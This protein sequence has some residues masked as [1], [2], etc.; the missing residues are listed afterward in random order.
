MKRKFWASTLALIMVLALCIGAFAA[1]DNGEQDP[2]TEPTYYTVTFDLDGG[3]IA[4]QDV[5]KGLQIEKGA[6]LNLSNY[7][8]T[9]EG[10]SFNG[11]KAGDMA[12]AQDDTLTINSNVTL[13]AQWTANT[14]TVTFILA[15]GE[16][17]ETTLSL[18]YGAT[19][20]FSDY[21]PTRG[22]YAFQGWKAGDGTEYT[23][24]DSLTVQA[25]ITLTAQWDLDVSPLDQ[26]EFSE[27][28]NGEVSLIG[29]ADSFDLE[30]VVLPAEDADGN[31]ITA[32]G[33]RAFQNQY[34]N[35]TSSI[36][37]IYLD[38]MTYLKAIGQHAFSNIASLEVLSLC[39]LSNLTEIQSSAFY[40][41]VSSGGAPGSL[42]SVDFTG[43]ESL[44]I[45]QQSAFWHQEKLKEVDL[46]GCTSL[47]NIERQAFA[48]C[49]SLETVK[50]PYNLQYIGG[51]NEEISSKDSQFFWDCN[52][53]KEI[54]VDPLNLYF[55]SENGVFYT[56]GK[57]DL[58]K[59]PVASDLSEY[60]A[61]ASV[62]SVWGQAFNGAENLKKIDFS[63]CFL[64]NIDSN[65]FTGCINAEL[66]VPFDDRGYYQ[67]GT[68]C[69][70]GNNWNG[71]VK[72][73]VFGEKYYF[74]EPTFKGIED[75]M[76]TAQETLSFDAEV[77]Y[78]KY[79]CSLTVM[80]ETT[81]TAGT[82]E[83][84]SYSV[85]LQ[86]GENEITVIARCAEKDAEKTF[87]FTVTLDDSLTVVS[88]LKSEGLNNVSDGY[89]FTV[90]VQN[91]EGESIS[92]QN[93]LKVAVDCGYSA[94][95]YTDLIEG[96]LYTVKYNTDGTVAT[97]ALDFEMLLSWFY[98]VDEPFHIKISY[99]LNDTESIDAIYEM[100]YGAEPTFTV[101]GINNNFEFSEDLVIT[102][103][104][105]D[106]SGAPVPVE[107]IQVKMT[108]WAGNWKDVTYSVESSANGVY[109][110]K[111]SYDSINNNYWQGMMEPFSVAIILTDE[112]G[113]E[114]ARVEFSNCD[115]A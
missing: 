49:Y 38:G 22:G 41:D 99:I 75:G 52:S 114:S 102:V 26:F 94:P 2:S 40:C 36:K 23:A 3:T 16:M 18:F 85:A 50:L 112:S 113:A 86:S 91:V 89:E 90:S 92:V 100:Q 97:I 98:T 88:S 43:C 101:E 60:I 69:E 1:C 84:G 45:I 105:K 48:F 24:D 106:A 61:P 81:Q 80:N 35:D 87:T 55:E 71:G 44:E 73:T 17:D 63:K 78:G 64:Q 11:W 13:T 56:A 7:V 67:D 103:I 107:Q 68:Q 83:N 51:Y 111:L 115:L 59:Y 108:L 58:I 33:N 42:Q 20:D 39:G 4:G 28:E 19:L 12:Y 37:Y 31:K 96:T 110:L 29:V 74:F 30:T 46:S 57:T 32:I 47:K 15:G 82:G 25:N 66:T 53:L 109:E 9:K 95:A 5:S 6:T 70:L 65:V 14:Y 8:P 104:A 93:K 54:I 10:N 34:D 27:P 72:N 77:L 76:T 21:I 79:T 62:T